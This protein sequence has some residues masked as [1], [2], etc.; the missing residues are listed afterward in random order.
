MA[1]KTTKLTRSDTQ[2]WDMNR[3]AS[4]K[5]M[6]RPIDQY[7]RY[8]KWYRGEL[9]AGGDDENYSGSGERRRGTGRWSAGL[10]NYTNL[11]T[12]MARAE[13]FYRNPRFLVRPP[14]TG[15]MGGIFTPA[16]AHVESEVLNA[17]CERIG[18]YR[19]G[20]RSIL[21]ALLGPFGAL[22]VGYRFDEVIE[23]IEEVQAERAKA[24]EESQHYLLDG[25]KPVVK[26]DDLHSVHISQHD[27]V[28]AAA[29]SGDLT[30]PKKALAYLKKHRAIH[31]AKLK[32]ERPSET[33]RND[34]VYACTPGIVFEPD[35]R[36]SPCVP[37][38]SSSRSLV[39]VRYSMSVLVLRMESWRSGPLFSIF[40]CQV[41]AT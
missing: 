31:A 25:T 28:I 36:T 17:E 37:Q 19:E 41:Q 1:E 30:L 6:Q 11:A 12:R 7:V 21:D 22:E 16:L 13:L 29:E 2:F 39:I 33:L 18:L 10:N 9:D 8:A 26:D 23:D 24:D 34:S 20:R 40:S 38:K 5:M 4:R 27:Q 35:E 3:A 14:S 15:T 32:Y